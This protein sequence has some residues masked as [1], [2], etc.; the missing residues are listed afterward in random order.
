MRNDATT[1][2]DQAWVDANGPITKRDPDRALVL[3]RRAVAL[4]PD[5][6][7]LNTLGVALYR[8]GQYAEAIPVL[9]QSLATGKGDFAAYDLFLLAMAHQKLGHA[10]QARACY[11]RAVRWCGEQKNLPAENAS[12]LTDFR[13]EAEDVLAE[14][15]AQLPAEVFAPSSSK[16]GRTGR[17]RVVQ[18]LA[19]RRGVRRHRRS[20]L[21]HPFRSN[22]RLPM[23]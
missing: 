14:T 2:N 18:G 10:S 7:F 15:P 20:L 6:R 23:A 4:L 3:A 8:V 9:D 19:P 5:R 21:A 1:L 12:E 11:D 13:A 17:T 16:Q 22:G